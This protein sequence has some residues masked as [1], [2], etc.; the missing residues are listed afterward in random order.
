MQLDIVPAINLKPHVHRSDLPST[1]GGQQ[2]STN[3]T[4]YW[5]ACHLLSKVLDKSLYSEPV[6]SVEYPIPS[7]QNI[8]QLY[9]GMSDRAIAWV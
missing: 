2:S 8:V 6:T 3:T 9:K 4:V 5:T 1:L 7:L